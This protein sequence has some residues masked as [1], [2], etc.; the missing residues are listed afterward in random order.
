MDKISQ[1]KDPHM[2]IYHYA[3]YEIIAQKNFRALRK[4]GGCW[5]IYC[6]RSVY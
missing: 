5:M 6:K 2:H 4:T 1:K 3:P